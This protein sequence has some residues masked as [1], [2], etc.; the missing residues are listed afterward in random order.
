V[1]REIEA[2]KASTKLFF[3][4][5]DNFAGD[6]AQA[7]ELLPELARQKVRWMSQMSID[8]AHDPEFLALLAQ[9][10]CQGVLIGFESLDAANLAAMNKRFNTMRGGY[11]VALE[12]LRRHDIRVY[13]TF[14]FG[15]EHDTLDSF[16]EA[17][18]FAI[19]Q[20]MYI[21]AFNHLTPFPG[22]PLYQRL[23]TEGRLR[24]DAWWFDPAYRYNDVPFIP[25]HLRPEE[26]TE[27][28]VRARRRFYSLTSIVRRGMAPINRGNAFIWRNF[29]SI[30]LMHRW[31]VGGRNGYPLGDENWQ[32]EL[33]EAVR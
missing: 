20:R 26:I 12:N 18:D 7:K 23:K 2:L 9:S 30:N 8:A 21:A 25:A 24:Y 6:I 22:T 33:L 31:D 16:D 4:I 28:C 14:V 10:G 15:Y 32:G 27:H 11:A 19:E 13:G 1:L 3:F 29:W 17:V 5:D